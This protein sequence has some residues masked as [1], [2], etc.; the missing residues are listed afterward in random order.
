MTIYHNHHII[1]RHMGGTDDPSNLVRLTV[2]EHAEAH[3]KLY[4]EHGKLE[5][6]VAWKMLSGKTE[7]GERIRIELAKIG[8]Q[9][10]LSDPEKHEG[11]RNNIAEKR[12]D[13][14]ITEEHKKSISR[15][16]KLAYKEGR[17]KWV[18]SET[19]DYSQNLINNKE[20]MSN[21]RKN[22]ETWHQAMRSEE[23][24]LKKRKSTGTRVVLNGIEYFS[25]RHA[26]ESSGIGYSRIRDAVSKLGNIISLD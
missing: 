2:E 18:R 21:A 14:V 16:L 10:F 12:K 24:R 13:Q 20:K 7:E 22:S 26:A 4:E 8:F 9:K 25:I 23:C 1:P 15:G 5:D 17:H 11:W 19:F 6:K 3:R